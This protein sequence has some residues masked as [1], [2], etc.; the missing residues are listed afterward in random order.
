MT[1]IVK[2]P[3]HYQIAEDLEA[4]DIIDAVV[5]KFA[6]TPYEGYLLGNFLKYRLRLGDKDDLEQDLAKSNQYRARLRNLRMPPELMHEPVGE[7]NCDGDCDNCVCCRPPFPVSCTI[8]RDQEENAE[9]T[10]KVH[11]R[12]DYPPNWDE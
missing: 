1:D 10:R 9:Y 4:I 3:S 12:G 2:K 6:R 7:G 5:E 11:L 8:L